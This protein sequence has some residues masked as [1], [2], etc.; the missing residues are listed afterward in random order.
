MSMSQF[1]RWMR[2]QGV[3]KG[4]RGYVMSCVGAV[5]ELGRRD[6]ASDGASGERGLRVTISTR[7]QD[8][9]G[10]I[11][12]PGGAQV[13]AFL[14]NPVVLW[15]HEHRSLPIGRV[16][17]L[18]REGEALKA[19]VVFAETPFAQEVHGLYASGFLK[20]WSVG[21]LPLEWEVLEDGEG[22]FE[23]Y[24]IRSWELVEL[25]AVPVPANA[26]ALT[27]A[28]V[29]GLVG[30]P[31]LRKS[32]EA[33]VLRGA[34]GDGVGAADVADRMEAGGD[35]P[36]ADEARLS[37]ISLAGLATL[38]A[39]KLAVRLRPLVG[40]SVGREIRRRQGRLD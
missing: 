21:F 39:P 15:A 17:T 40:E 36:C 18:T 13:A 11:L 1:N 26:E 8:R 20:A 9:H 22:R 25:S 38:L 23:G 5:E 28:L 7:R 27:E 33:A 4:P 19:E 12:E 37:E 30:E 34:A 16:K 14:K 3:T 10:D 24:H 29:K 6:G 32:L 2:E 35:K 31:A